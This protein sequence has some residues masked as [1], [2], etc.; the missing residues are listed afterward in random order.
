MQAAGFKQQRQQVITGK[1][2]AI[3]HAVDKALVSTGLWKTDQQQALELNNLI[4]K[5]QGF[6][7]ATSSLIGLTQFQLGKSV[8]TL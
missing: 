7:A 8:N 6:H 5:A 2:T 1:G 3:N 4:G